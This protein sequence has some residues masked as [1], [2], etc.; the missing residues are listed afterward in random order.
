MWSDIY[1]Q[2][3]LKTPKCFCIFCKIIYFEL[4]CKSA[5][6]YTLFLYGTVLY[7]TSIGSHHKPVAFP[8]HSIRGIDDFSDYRCIFQVIDD[9]TGILI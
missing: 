3:P 6:N 1:T 5:G 9:K 7:H 4:V 8:V 2:M